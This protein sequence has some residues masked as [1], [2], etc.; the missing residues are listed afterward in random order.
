MG[1]RAEGKH[2]EVGS[3]PRTRIAY[4]AR[5]LGWQRAAWQVW[6]SPASLDLQKLALSW[7]PPTAVP[8]LAGAP[9]GPPLRMAPAE[10]I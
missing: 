7:P 3:H 10:G 5:L 1:L 4:P 9:G 6:C 8:G 2:H